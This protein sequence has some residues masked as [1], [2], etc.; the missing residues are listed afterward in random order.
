MTNVASSLND[1]TLG[2][3]TSPR[4]QV[5][6]KKSTPLLTTTPDADVALEPN[7]VPS[8]IF[9]LVKDVVDL[10]KNNFMKECDIVARNLKGKADIEDSFSNN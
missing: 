7:V 4:T 6:T 10:L 5:F 8:L 1:V 9:A 3:A 2:V